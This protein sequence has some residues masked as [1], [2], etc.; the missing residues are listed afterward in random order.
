MNNNL[1]CIP[2]E[3]N[4]KVKEL[5]RAYVPYQNLCGIFDVEQGLIKGTIF[6]E[7]DRPYCKGDSNINREENPCNKEKNCNN[8]RP[9]NPCENM[10]KPIPF[11]K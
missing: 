9:C 2:Y 8:C 10:P 1:N 4:I 7:L 11:F 3:E 6:P 5:A